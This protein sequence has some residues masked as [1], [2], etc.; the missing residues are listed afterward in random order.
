MSHE[1]AESNGGSAR[2]SD[3]DLITAAQH[4]RQFAWAPYSH[5]LVGAALASTTGQIVAGANVESAAFPSG[6][7]AERSA[8]GT[9]VAT[10]QAMP[11]G[12]ATVVVV[13]AGANPVWPC[14]QCRQA[15]IEF[16]TPHTRVLA[17]GPAGEVRAEMTL[18][19]L[20]PG[21]F[22]SHQLPTGRAQG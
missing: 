19:E 15:L 5:F 12:L 1:G 21:A 11:G 2:V 7:C 22:T 18:G 4:V 8:L 13:A 3:R 17:V 6:L 14:G 10:G 9:W 20:L 16:G